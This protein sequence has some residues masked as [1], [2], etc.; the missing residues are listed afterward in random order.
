ML[1]INLTTDKKSFSI[2]LLEIEQKSTMLQIKNLEALYAINSVRNPSIINMIIP[3][4]YAFQMSI[5][6]IYVFSFFF[7]I[8]LRV[9]YG[10]S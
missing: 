8:R 6:F 9:I 7:L 5:Q 10:Y 4:K 3:I 2:K 1:K